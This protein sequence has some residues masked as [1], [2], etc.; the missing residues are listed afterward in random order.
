MGHLSRIK[1]AGRIALAGTIATLLASTV[2]A[3]QTIPLPAIDVITSRFGPGITGA[4]TS[5]ITAEDIARSPAQTIPDILAQQPGIQVRNLFGSVNAASTTVDMRGFGA[6]ASANTLVLINGRRLNDI[7]LAGVDFGAIPKESIERIEIIRGN[8]GAVLYGDNAVGGTINIVTKSGVGLPPSLR[9]G[10]T[11]ASY[12]YWAGDVSMN[13][14]NGPF[15]IAAYGNLVNSDGYRVNNVLRQRNAVTELRHTGDTGTVFAN[16]SA[17]WQSLGFPGG[18]LVTATTSL[19]DTNRR[20]AATPFDHGLKQG[21]NLTT[22][23]T[24][25]LANGTEL[26][27]DGGIRYKNQKAEFFSAFGSLF[28]AAVDTTLATYSVT[29]RINSAHNLFVVPS[30]LIAGVDVYYSNYNS[31]RMNHVG[32]SPYH[33]YDITQRS[34]AAYFQNTAAVRSDTDLATGARV[35]NNSISARDRLDALAPGGLFAAPQGVPLDRSESQYALHAGLDHR[36]NQIFAVFARL[37]RSFR[38]PNVDE[39]V[40]QGPFGVPTSFDLRPQTSFDLEGGMRVQ[41]GAVTL[42]SS[43]YYMS[44]TNEIFFSPATFTNVNLDPTRRT[45]V[46]N[47]A[48]LQVNN[49]LRVKAGL[50]YT[51]AV[52]REGPFAGNDIPLVARWTGMAGFSWDVLEDKRLLVDV[53][54]RY[55]GESRMDNDSRNVQPLIP[56]HTVV[57]V[58]IGGQIDRVNWSIA[59]LNVFDALYYEYAIASAFTLGTFN[60]YPLPGRTVWG[61]LAV[62]LQ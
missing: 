24:R 20:G 33:R 38:F 37:G 9:G 42:Q 3:Q 16:V 19:L 36:I 45:G 49:A 5:I 43:T 54:A 29:P 25:T 41:W 30:K 34:I 32:Q 39:R 44:L 48:T 58:K 59:V 22:G 10:I 35:H 46:E 60:A 31:S 53:V 12:N 56:A 2:Q 21:V 7:D 15:S 6:A 18:R 14:S 61:R 1:A 50:A 13:S 62:N 52:F 28:D 23:V 40:G 47:S 51:R 4:S 17:D 57:D 27:V 8:A 26:I 11:G 55:V